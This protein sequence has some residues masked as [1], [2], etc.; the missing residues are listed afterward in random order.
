MRAMASQQVKVSSW[1]S[2]PERGRPALVHLHSFHQPVLPIQTASQCCLIQQYQ[3]L[4]WGLKQP[5][6]LHFC[7]GWEK[8][9][10]WVWWNELEKSS[11][12]MCMEAKKV[13]ACQTQVSTGKSYDDPAI[14]SHSK[15]WQNLKEERL[16]IRSLYM[17]VISSATPGWL[18]P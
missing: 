11:M 1:Q 16:G 10:S 7:A 6:L 12:L 3:N 9:W 8:G 18:V 17:M 5:L 14:Q 2:V 15:I 13:T 4:L